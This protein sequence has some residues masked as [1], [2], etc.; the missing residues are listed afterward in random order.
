[1]ARI[2]KGDTVEVIAG[3]DKGKTGR[4]LT[5]IPKKD[6]LVIQGINLRWKHMRRSQ[7]HPQ[8]GRIRREVPIHISNVM[9][10]DEATGGRTRIGYAIT[11][12]KKVRMARKTGQAIG[13]AAAPEEKTAKKSKAKKAKEES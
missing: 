9:L 2:R 6:R 3:N 5:M 4:V 1:M 7:Q 11:D 12:G 13:A 8:G 10:F